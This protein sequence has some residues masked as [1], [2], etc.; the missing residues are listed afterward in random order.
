MGRG[1]RGCGPW[2][3]GLWRVVSRCQNELSE[4]SEIHEGDPQGTDRNSLHG[5]QR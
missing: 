2:F 1:L 4:C 5:D 3:E